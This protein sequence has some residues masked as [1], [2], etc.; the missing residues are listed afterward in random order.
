MHVITVGKN[1]G[2]ELEG[3]QEGAHGK[4]WRGG[5]VRRNVV[6]KS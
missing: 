4:V 5:E 3:E 2:H 6:I 1:G